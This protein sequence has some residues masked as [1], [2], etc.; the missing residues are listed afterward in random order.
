VQLQA[1]RNAAWDERFDHIARHFEKDKLSIDDWVCAEENRSK[2]ELLEEMDRY[3]YDDDDERG[4]VDAVGDV[5]DDVPLPP[6]PPGVV[7]EMSIPRNAAPPPPPPTE[8]FTS[9]DSNKRK[10]TEEPLLPPRRPRRRQTT[11][12]TNRYCVSYPS[13]TMISDEANLYHS[14]RVEAPVAL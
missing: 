4:D 13:N 14:V 6:P 11:L 10:A 9:V 5:D 7:P 2:K 3:I 8:N 12:I 1:R